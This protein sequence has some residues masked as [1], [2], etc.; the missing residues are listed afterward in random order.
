MNGFETLFT[1]A[2]TLIALLLAVIAYFLRQFHY[3]FQELKR[4]WHVLSE[5]LAVNEAKGRSGYRELGERIREQ[6]GRITRLET[7]VFD[8]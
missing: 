1:I 6:G 8:K 2:S 4:E 7:K 3:E 5:R